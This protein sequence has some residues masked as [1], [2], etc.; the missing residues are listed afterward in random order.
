ML[1]P[2]MKLEYTTENDLPKLAWFAQVRNEVVHVAHGRRVETRPDFFADGLW[3]GEFSATGL[4]RSF[5]VGTGATITADS[6]SFRSSSAP[7]DRLFTARSN[8]SVLV[9]NSLPC[10]LELLHDGLDPAERRYR[11]FFMSAENGVRIAPRTFRT[12]GGRE[13]THVLCQTITIDSSGATTVS[14]DPLHRPFRDFDD[15]RSTLAQTFKAILD[16][17]NDPS[18]RTTYPA[19]IPLSSGYD[20]SAVAALAAEAGVRDAVTMLRYSDSG[21]PLDHPR[22]VADALGLRLDEV[23]RDRWRT[24]TDLPE[25]E[26]A[27]TATT[28]MDAVMLTMEDQLADRAVLVGYPGDIAWDVHNFRCYRDLVQGFGHLSGRSMAE[29]RLRTGLQLCA[30]PFVGMTAHPS[31]FDISNSAEM[32]PWRIGG[33]YDRPI[34][35]RIIEG[36][37]VARGAFAVRKFGGSAR[38]GSSRTR[39]EGNTRNERLTE[40]LEV[41]TPAGANSFLDFC[42]EHETTGRLGYWPGRAGY[43]VYQKLD[44]INYRVGRRLHGRGVRALVPRRWMML[45]ATRYKIDDDY[46]YLLPHWG[47]HILQARYRAACRHH[48]RALP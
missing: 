18:R 5:L 46:A 19:V 14:D 22:A 30:V 17:S 7:L 1:G 15:Y 12:S 38:V 32:Q 10:I 27:A 48:D 16:N 36:A 26:L 35:R 41:M 40:M 25:A 9:S 11:S 44:A 34:A 23:A 3:A 2:T 45:L 33:R 29:Y 43:F 39:Y 6:V 4:E 28:M 37:G 8:S 31:I 21:E 13:V 20:S 47:T 24:R 42:E